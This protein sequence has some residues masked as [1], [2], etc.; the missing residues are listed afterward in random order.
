MHVLVAIPGKHHRAALSPLL[1][2]LG[3]RI[4][5]VATDESPARQAN[6][7]TIVS[8]FR[9]AMKGQSDTAVFAT[10]CASPWAIFDALL[11]ET[12]NRRALVFYEPAGLAI[13]RKLEGGTTVF[14]AAAIWST[15]AR[16]L[17]E[18]AHANSR[19]VTLVRVDEALC[20]PRAFLESCADRFLFDLVDCTV[21]PAAS[22]FPATLYRLVAESI[23]QQMLALS[24]L[25]AR[26]SSHAL[27]LEA[28]RTTYLGDLDPFI[29]KYRSLLQDQRN[30]SR[31][32]AEADA[33]R[34]ANWLAEDAAQALRLQLAAKDKGYQT[35]AS[36]NEI[37]AGP[38]GDLREHI[39]AIESEKAHLLETL[40]DVQAIA[41]TH[42]SEAATL[43][44]R[45]E[46]DHRR[47]VKLEA[48]LRRTASAR[49]AASEAQS[50]APEEAAAPAR[51][52]TRIAPSGMRNLA[53]LLRPRLWLR[54]RRD[55][56]LVVRSDFFDADWYI[57]RNA[58]I[59]ALGV[60]PAKH[61][62]RYGGQEGRAPGPAFSSR[63]YLDENPDV[64]H[65]GLNPL[66]HYLRL[67][68]AEG[69]KI[70]R[71]E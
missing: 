6:R 1:S 7:S 3:E 53:A 27:A 68:R 29:A 52:G 28:G 30:L 38:D 57:E 63:C 34:T 8:A 70:R 4:V 50:G 14:D 42:V 5:P 55:A 21:K 22:S 9:E 43:R 24:T 13:A 45:L 16:S 26:L 47:L 51:N 40:A 11:T 15:E 37:G 39:A 48:E 17:V 59:Q 54:T 44:A 23:V 66:L 67:G 31:V 32:A 64:A 61:F 60:D 33:L 46:A 36:S 71:A 10:T 25:D 12:T 20:A 56:N 41:E 65:A 62:V 2:A 18:F 58:D 69:R 49:L 35:G 19:H